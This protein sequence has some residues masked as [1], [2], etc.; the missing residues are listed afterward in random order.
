MSGHYWV[1]SRHSLAANG[2]ALQR[3]K[4]PSIGV[5]ATAWSKASSGRFAYPGSRS[6]PIDAYW[7]LSG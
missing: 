1:A 6:A 4:P 5:G 2:M 7:P 3:R